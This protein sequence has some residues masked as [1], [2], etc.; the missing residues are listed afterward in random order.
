MMNK[1]S[2][3]LEQMLTG[4]ESE[5]RITQEEFMDW[6]DKY[7]WE[8]I[9]GIPFKSRGVSLHHQRVNGNL[10]QEL[11]WYV[12]DNPVSIYHYPLHVHL[13]LFEE[14]STMVQPD[15]AVYR[16]RCYN[17]CLKEVGA[18]DFIVEVMM[19]ETMHRDGNIKYELYK[20]Y[21]VKEYWRVDPFAK[22]INKY[23]LN[24]FGKYEATYYSGDD[25]AFSTVLPGYKVSLED[26]FATRRRGLL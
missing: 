15:I 2:E 8:L 4:Y 13:H 3:K 12:G 22:Q 11:S 10:M 25:Q 18:P 9:E 6:K 20:K 26:A 5:R 24:E 21:G 7:N 23:V 17:E 14:R 19:I 1:T 16:D